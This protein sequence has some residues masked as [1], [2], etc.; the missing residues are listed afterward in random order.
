M[1][2]SI[3]YYFL[4]FVFVDSTILPITAHLDFKQD[5]SLSCVSVV[6]DTAKSKQPVRRSSST[7][8]KVSLTSKAP[9]EIQNENEREIKKIFFSSARN[10][11]TNNVS[12]ETILLQPGFNS[13]QLS[14]KATRVGLW[15]FKQ[16]NLFSYFPIDFN[17]KN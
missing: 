7:R 15:S 10:D 9:S 6:C 16:V 3:F 17:R 8:R 12:T 1:I 5:N 14:T 4:F 2:G 11:F 13:I